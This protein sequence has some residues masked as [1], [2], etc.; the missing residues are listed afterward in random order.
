M[1]F[2]PRRDAADVA[3][4]ALLSLALAEESDGEAA[5]AA[6]A[7]ERCLRCDWPFSVAMAW[8]RVRLSDDDREARAGGCETVRCD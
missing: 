2:P 6:A 3:S 7:V 1:F 4:I 5:A 8:A